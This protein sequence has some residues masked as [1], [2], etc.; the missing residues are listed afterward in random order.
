MKFKDKVFF[1]TGASR[2][3][4]AE[5]ALECGRQGAM[6]LLLARDNEKMEM[7]Y[8]EIV[9]QGGPTP[10]IIK[11]D[12]L[13]ADPNAYQQ[14]AERVTQSVKQLDGLF[15]LAT[16]QPK[17]TP[18]EHYDIR[19]W[20][21][22]MQVN[23]HAPFLLTQALLPLLKKSPQAKIVFTKSTDPKP[24]WGAHSCAQG[25][26]DNLQL[27]LKQELENTSIEIESVRPEPT[28]TTF[29]RR[30]YPAEDLSLLQSPKTAA[31]EI[32]EVI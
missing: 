23:C 18:I 25:A 8:D 13:S 9:A 28:D 20:F 26:M 14:L 27:I 32:L 29:R 12:L 21:E 7:I 6:C 24:Y 17:L 10:I 4:G 31:L 11:L 19:H 15:H 5:L 1:I 3:I 22:V 2:G 30:A 16:H